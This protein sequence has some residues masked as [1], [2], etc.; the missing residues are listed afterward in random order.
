MPY[1][2]PATVAIENLYTLLAPGASGTTADRSGSIASGGTAQTL[3]AANSNRQR[4]IG[5]NI[6]SEPLWI[7]ELGGTA[8][9]DTVGSYRISSYAVFEVQTKLAVSIVGLTTGQKWTAFEQSS[10]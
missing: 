6:S 2:D 10:V 4:L 5:Q 9:A 3:A 7:N 1:R 8:T